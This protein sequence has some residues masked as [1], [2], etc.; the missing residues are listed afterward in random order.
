V[1]R[2]TG[3]NF[4][5]ATTLATADPSTTVQWYQ[6]GNDL[7]ARTAVQAKVDDTQTVSYGAQAN[8]TGTLN[9]LRSFAVLAIQN[10]T[11]G[12]PK[13][14][15][16]YDAVATRNLDR[17]SALHASDQGSIEMVGVELSN[18]QVALKDIS[19]RHDS[20][21]SQLQGMLTNIETV[22]NEETAMEMLAL[23]TRLTASYQAT[24]MISQLSLVNYI[25]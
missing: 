8:E 10:F 14:E 19:T 18:T 15:A 24:S 5:T 11:A 23:Q 17:V 21:T 4:A 9:L 2:V 3:P 1:L 6:G 7:N 12:D 22:S 20:Y 13:S 25:K 16:R